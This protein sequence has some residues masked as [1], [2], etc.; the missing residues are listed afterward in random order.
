MLNR[1]ETEVMSAIFK[2]CDDT[3]GCMVSLFDIL[4]VLPSGRKYTPEKIEKILNELHYDGYFDLISSVRKGEKT[5]VITLKE[6]GYAF[7]RTVKQAQR[8]IFFKIFL[9][10]I[11]AVAT[12]VFGLLLNSIF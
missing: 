1:A 10:F 12:F 11:G 4:S 2:L 7:K 9:A 5:Y 3:D 6:N 8:D